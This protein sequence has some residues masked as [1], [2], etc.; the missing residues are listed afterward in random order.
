MQRKPLTKF[1]KI[2]DRNSPESKHRRTYL[3][4]IKT[5]C[6]KSTANII[7]NFEILAA[8]PLKSGICQGHPFLPLLFN[9]VLEILAT[10]IREE[11]E[12]KSRL[13]EK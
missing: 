6:I 7:F 8:F 1:N 10:E 3:N 4:T 2:C 11:K 12:N 9:I 5:I 13:E